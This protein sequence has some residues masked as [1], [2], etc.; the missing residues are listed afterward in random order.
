MHTIFQ[1]FSISVQFLLDHSKQCIDCF[2]SFSISVKYLL[3][4]SKQCIHY[5]NCFLFLYNFYWIIQSTAYIVSI[6]LNFCTIFIRSFKAIHTLFQLF[7]ILY[8]IYLIIQ[9]NA[10]IVSIV[11]NF[12]TIFIGSFKAMHTLFQLF[13]ITVQYYWIIQSN[14]YIVS[15]VFHYCTI[16]I[17]SFKAMHTLFQLFSISLQYLLD[18]SKQCIH[19]FNCFPLLYKIY[20]IIQSNAYIIS[21]VFH[22]STIFIG[23][24]K[25]MHTLFQLYSI[26]VEYLLDHSKQCIHYFNCFPFLYNIYW[27]IQSNVY[28]ISIVFHFSLK[29]M[30]FFDCNNALSLLIFYFAYFWS[31]KALSKIKLEDNVA[32][33]Y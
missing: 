29:A 15:T 7:L 20:W 17:G 21:I 2:N 31:I 30:T 1:L 6:V 5:F 26:S 27:I 4:H 13:S 32:G 28:I 12:C 25:A 16:F 19:C 9:S 3:D 24:F 8:N 10:Y 11:F 23:S 33:L 22:F 14:A 18:H